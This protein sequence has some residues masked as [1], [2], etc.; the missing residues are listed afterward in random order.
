[1]TQADAVSA[2][3]KGMLP[4]V[5]IKNSSL[6]GDALAVSGYQ[7]FP[8]AGTITTLKM[9]TQFQGQPEKDGDLTAVHKDYVIVPQSQKP[10]SFH[11]GGIKEEGTWSTNLELLQPS[12]QWPA[13][14][15]AIFVVL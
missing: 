9:R 11:V 2:A 6:F 12:R 10:K 1:M 8:K 5:T 4:L 14:H 13:D 15:F 7:A 3:A